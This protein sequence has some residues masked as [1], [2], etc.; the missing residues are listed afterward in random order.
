MH[1]SNDSERDTPSR[2]DNEAW[3][4]KPWK[5]F[6]KVVFRLQKRLYAARKQGD[7]KKV[8]WLQRKLLQ[9]RAAMFLAVKKV[10]QLNSGK[11]TP[12]V[13]GKTALTDT[14]KMELVKRLEKEAVAWTPSPARRV[15]I[16]KAD[17]T[18]RGLGIP[19]IAD[20]A[21]QALVVLALEPCAEA[22]FHANSYGFRPGRGCWDAHK[23]I[24][25]RTNS[26]PIGKSF[27]GYVYELDIEKCFDRINH[28]NLIKRVELPSPYRHALFKTLQSGVVIDF[29]SYESTEQ[30]TPQGGVL[31][32]LLANIALN[33]VESIGSCVRYADDMVFILR[34]RENAEC[35]RTD[36][37]NFLATRGLNIKASK[38][39]LVGMKEGFD[40]L[41]LNFFLKPNGTS[42]SKPKQGWLNPTKRK[43][44]DLMKS[45]RYPKDELARKIFRIADGKRRF[46][47]YTDL[48]K[49]AGQWWHLSQYV[50]RRLGFKLPSLKYSLNRHINVK[51]EKSP[52][53]G[54]WTYWVQ[55]NN[56][57]YSGDTRSKILKHQDGKCGLCG[58]YMTENMDIHLHHKD[59]DHSN[60]KL[61]NLQFVHRSCH[62]NHHRTK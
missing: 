45:S 6:E 48:A 28:Q 53:D 16:P 54:D 27:S 57:R 44:R 50:Y 41:G 3:A 21:W 34:N 22:T 36:I 14:E 5:K 26:G 47:Q 1:I 42:S 52:Y 58:L 32:P 59:H 39:R 11:R 55:R 35:L 8:N 29:R 4:E 61:N 40:F 23:I 24:W 31:S 43:I 7:L 60:N 33:G 19:T 56:R 2:F 25:L 9:S 38:T 20:R 46:Y 37:D 49:G 10:T 15:F 51:G 12:G 17:G 30:G 18:Q 62:M 13:D